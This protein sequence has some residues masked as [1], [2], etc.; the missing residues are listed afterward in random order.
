MHLICET[1]SLAHAAAHGSC[2]AAAH[3]ISCNAWFLFGSQLM[4]YT[5]ALGSC[6]GR[7]P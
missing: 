7:G 5:A 3:D 4:A 1:Q 6:L 2:W